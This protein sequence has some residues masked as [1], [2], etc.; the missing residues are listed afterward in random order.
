MS[1]YVR[2]S[3]KTHQILERESYARGVPMQQVADEAIKEF[4]SPGESGER[5]VVPKSH[6]DAVRWFLHLL[7]RPHPDPIQQKR[8]EYFLSLAEEWKRE[9]DK[10]ETK[11]SGSGKSSKVS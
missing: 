5:L 8:R 9:V 2:I 3:E 10:P 6:E 7:T 11:R 4:L 1:K